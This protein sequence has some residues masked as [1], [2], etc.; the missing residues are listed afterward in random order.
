MSALASI[1]DEDL[2]GRIRDGDSSAFEAVMRKYN[3]RLFR[4]ARAILR[5]EADA[6]EA[7]QNTYIQAYLHLNQFRRPRLVSSNM[8]PTHVRHYRPKYIGAP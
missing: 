1:V 2:L 6:E 3:Q 8:D 4:V 7:V 5:N